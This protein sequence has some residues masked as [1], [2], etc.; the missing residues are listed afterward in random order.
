MVVDRKTSIFVCTSP[1]LKKFTIC[2]F[3]K[4]ISS[5]FYLFEYSGQIIALTI[6]KY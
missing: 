1:Q 3:V 6:I 5:F 2:F 4:I